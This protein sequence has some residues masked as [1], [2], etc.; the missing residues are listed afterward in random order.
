MGAE[1][2]DIVTVV[3][4]SMGRWHLL[5]QTLEKVLGQ[6]G[7]SPRV[8]VVLDAR[9]GDE[10]R[11][12]IAELQTDRVSVVT[13]DR[14]GGPGPARNVGVD[15]VTTEWV[16]FLDDDDLWSPDKLRVQ[17][18]AAEA[19]EADWV[20]GGGLVVDAE[21]RVLD[22]YDP[23]SPHEVDRLLRSHNPLSGG[24][25]D[26]LMKTAL[27]RDV[28]GF[29]PSFKHI[30]DHDLW[31]RLAVAGRPGT[32][33]GFHVAYVKHDENMS[34]TDLDGVE[35]EF[36]RFGDK[37]QALGVNVERQYRWL[38]IGLYR[39]GR[40]RDAAR[41]Y[42]QTAVRHRAPLN[43][44]RALVVL[45]GAR[46]AEWALRRRTHRPPAAPAWLGG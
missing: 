23:P 39:D 10:V 6:E 11:D 41:V 19:A 44:A 34:H 17:L 27:F 29:D 2:Q 15:H 16:A 18:R 33:P 21:H 42:W 32:Y 24:S 40:P 43:L 37:H 20:Y 22:A 5:E 4:P 30:G 36:E 28:G 25:S 8:L 35:E 45:S 14:G 26:V 31:L 12:R 1:D 46:T 9:A 3:I 38:A 13:D 7:V